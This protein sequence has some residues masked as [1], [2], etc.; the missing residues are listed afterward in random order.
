MGPLIISNSGLSLCSMERVRD[1]SSILIVGL[2]IYSKKVCFLELHGLGLRVLLKDRSGLSMP[3]KRIF[4]N[5]AI[6]LEFMAR[7]FYQY[8]SLSY[9][10]RNEN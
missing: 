3:K 6:L 10:K 1:V 9:G 5:A 2:V 8:S 7:S 4:L